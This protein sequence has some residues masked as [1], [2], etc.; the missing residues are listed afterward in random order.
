MIP[1]EHRPVAG[2]RE[3]DAGTY[4]RIAD[5]QSRWGA[6]VLDRLDP[7]G[8]SVVLDAGCGSG[9]VTEQLLERLPTATVVALD[10]SSAMLDAARARLAVHADRVRYVQ[11]DLAGPLPVPDIGVVDAIV[12]TATFHWIADHGALFRHLA[13]VVRPGGQLVAQCGGAGNIASVTRALRQVGD[14]WPGPWTYAGAEETERRLAEAGFVE[15]VA[16][17]HDEPTTFES[18]AAFRQFLETVVLGAHLERLAADDRVAFVDAVATQLPGHTLDYV[19]LDLSARRGA[20][21]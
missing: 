13:D 14:G 1:H 7:E 6:T 12:S 11:A 21:R 16:W 15:A 9:R 5:P 20:G 19:R 18:E 8:V 10:G 4:D 17:L 2:S 3:W